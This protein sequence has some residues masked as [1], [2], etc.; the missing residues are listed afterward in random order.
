VALDQEILR[1]RQDLPPGGESPA[2]LDTV[3]RR[4]RGA[5]SPRT[6]SMLRASLSVPFIL[7]RD[8]PEVQKRREF[9]SLSPE[10]QKLQE[11]SGSGAEL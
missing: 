4:V 5:D 2:P 1:Q 3:Q 7:W 8:I 10:E 11:V 6:P 9:D